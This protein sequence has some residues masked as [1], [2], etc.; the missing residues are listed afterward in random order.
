MTRKKKNNDDMAVYL[1]KH[2]VIILLDTKC[3]DIIS[4]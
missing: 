2:V 4:S 3:R 1:I